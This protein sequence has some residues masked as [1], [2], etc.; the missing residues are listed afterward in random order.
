MP[1]E[2]ATL[3]ELVDRI[4]SDIKTR[5]TGGSNLLRRSVLMVLARVFAGAIHLLYGYLG[6]QSEQR[7]VAKADQTG[8]DDLAD[9]YGMTRN[10]PTYAQGSVQVTGTDGA[11]ISADEELQTSSGIK[12]TVDSAQTISGGVATLD[13]TASEAGSDGN[14]SSGAEL[15]FTTPISSVSQT[16]TV[17]SDGLTGGAD[18]ET[19]DE[20]R[21][22]LLIRK[23]YPPYGG[24]AYDYKAWM[25]ENSGITRAWVFTEYNGVGTVGCTFVMDNTDPYLPSAATLETIRDYMI[26][27]T[28]PATGR[29]V[30]I[31]VGAEP[32]LFMIELTEQ[33]MNFSLSIYPN[34][35]IV[36][37]AIEEELTD[38]ILR[39]GGPGETIYM[40]DIQSA[41][42]NIS[43]LERFAVTTPSSDVTAA[44]NK[45][46]ALG[47]ITYSDYS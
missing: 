13:I 12:Y 24:C 25:M 34:T 36:Q 4:S 7:F 11:T 47:T 37:D 6:Y 17:D 20:L 21:T 33:S 35:S 38:L 16:A 30:G 8:L 45:I 28:D 15:T 32:G 5:V 14:Q 26:E 42:S 9:E 19:D 39:D 41:L 27:H 1:F 31:P 29:I 2:R 23:Q 22:R 18:E 10:A 40:S 44:S 46:H 3:T 43:S